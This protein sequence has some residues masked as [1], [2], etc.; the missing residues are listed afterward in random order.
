MA[1][2]RDRRGSLGIR[3]RNRLPALMRRWPL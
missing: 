2:I 1:R 3:L